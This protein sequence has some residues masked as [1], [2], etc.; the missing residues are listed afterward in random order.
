MYIYIL[1]SVTFSP[2]SKFIL[3]GSLDN[4]LRLWNYTTGKCLKTYTGY[5]YM[6]MIFCFIYVKLCIYGHK[7]QD[8]KLCIYGHKFEDINVM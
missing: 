3:A 7:F 6:Y 5:I 1:L 4:K 8:T 2:N